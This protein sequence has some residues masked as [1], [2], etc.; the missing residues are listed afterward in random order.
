[1]GLRNL[2]CSTAVASAAVAA[3][4]AGAT[5]N[6]DEIT[7]TIF[8]QGSVVLTDTLTVGPGVDLTLALADFDFSAGPDGDEWLV[9]FNVTASV[10]GFA[11]TTGES[12]IELTGLD[13]SDDAELTGISLLDAPFHPDATVS[14]LSPRSVGLTFT[15][16]VE[17]AGDAGDVAF[18]ARF[19]TSPAGTA[20]IPLPAAGWL[21]FGGLGALGLLRRRRTFTPD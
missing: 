8:N 1:M 12:R 19:Q 16:G 11:G 7:Q 17:V 10:P 15:D 5:L 13:F 3:P 4:A 14:L 2:V 21:M 9:S 20:P 6:G 18:R